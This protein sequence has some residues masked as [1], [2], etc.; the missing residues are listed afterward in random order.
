MSRTDN[1]LDNMRQH[2]TIR[3]TAPGMLLSRVCMLTMVL[4]FAAAIVCGTAGAA[5][6]TVCSSG[7]DYTTIQAAVNAASAGDTII[8]GDGTYID[9]GDVQL[10][11]GHVFDQA[12]Y[13]L[14]CTCNGE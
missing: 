7:C 3:N 14:N 4:M 1:T 2:Q 13:P 6:I 12:G 9:S 10:L 8:V 5:T 11:M